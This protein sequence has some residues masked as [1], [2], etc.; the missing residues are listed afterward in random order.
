MHDKK[1]MMFYRRTLYF[2]FLA[3]VC[4]LAACSE[5]RKDPQPQ[6]GSLYQVEKLDEQGFKELIQKRDGKALFLNVWATWCVPCTEEFPDVVRLKN[7]YKDKNIEFVGVSADYPDEIESKIVPFI[8]KHK[9][10][11]RIYVMNAANEQAF[12]NMVDPDWNGGLPATFLYDENGVKK[13]YILG[14]RDF[15][16]FKERIEQDLNII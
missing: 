7:V 3:G 10:N 5:D 13:E 8:R 11:F 14:K 4:L 9:V 16:F 12:I 6:N 15:A 1:G 2:A